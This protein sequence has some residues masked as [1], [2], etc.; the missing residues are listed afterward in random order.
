MKISE[1]WLREWANP[2]L[3]SQ[4]LVDQLSVS[5]LEVDTAV[6]VVAEPL[7]GIVIGLV[8]E[9]VQHPDADRLRLCTVDVGGDG[10]LEI[11]CGAPNAR[12]GSK[13]PVAT[14]GTRLP[15]GVKIRKSKIRGVVSNGMLCSSRELGMGDEH[16]GILELPEAAPVGGDFVAFMGLDDIII[17]IE[18]T[19][20]RGDCLGIAGVAREVGVLNRVAVTAPVIEP[21]P[22]TIDDTFPITLDAPSACPRYV[23]RVIRNINAEAAT[24]SWM[25]EKLRRSGIRAIHPLV[26][27]TNYVMLELGQPMHAFDLAQLSGGI[28]VRY[29]Q[30]GETL[31]LLDDR[32]ITLTPDVLVIADEV[33]AVALAGIMGGEGSGIADDTQHLFLEC[34]FFAPLDIAGKARRFGLHTDASHRYERGVDPQLQR[35]ATE[36][37]TALLLDIVGGEPGPITEAVDSAH[38]PARNTIRLRPGRIERLLG[39]SIDAETVEDILSRLGMDVARD[40]DDWAVTAPSYRFDITIEA[41]LIEELARIVGF[42]N[43]PTVSVLAASDVMPPSEDR[44]T[45]ESLRHVLVQRGYQEAITFSFV[46]AETQAKMDPGA[47]ALPLSNPISSE[48]SLM[49]TNLWS[50]LLGAVVYNVNRQAERVRLFETGLRFR[51]EESVLVQERVIAGAILGPVAPKQ[52]GQSGHDA[53]FFDLKADVEALLDAGGKGSQYSFAAANVGS[54]H[55]GQSAVVSDGES[56]LGCLGALHPAI[57]ADYKLPAT[58][59]LF[60][61]ALDP[62][63]RGTL[64]VFNSLSRYPAV[65]RDLSMVVDESIQMAEVRACVGQCAGDMLK[66]FGLFDVYRGE[67]IDSGRKSLSLG[68]T[69]QADSRTLNDDEIDSA[70][71]EIVHGLTAQLGAVLRG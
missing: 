33:R 56:P 10:P 8:T 32:V 4:A 13:F 6:P 46:D 58:L 21:I 51:M 62:L 7:A 63:Q 17:D 20:N 1:A 43:M 22:A 49:R 42:D 12:A 31:K 60:E 59:Y 27:V 14:V 71:S 47:E 69:F 66:N 35:K 40:G 11:V 65:R 16:D 64:P 24:P 39:R 29:A 55:P 53:D 70:V 25:V 54:L 57:A 67:G 9:A 52:W 61:L 5:G 3:D 41:D 26:D 68:L 15:G 23:G 50:G 34:A 28:H 18:L 37:A 2:A 44:V 19:P 38:I 36:R 30:D 48:L 45:L